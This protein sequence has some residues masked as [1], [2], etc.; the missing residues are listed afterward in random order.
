LIQTSNSREDDW[1]GAVNLQQW[2]NDRR[3][4]GQDDF[5]RE[6]DQF[7][8]ITGI[9]PGTPAVVDLKVASN[10]PAQFPKPLQNA[11]LRACDCGSSAGCALSTPIRRVRALCCARAAS[12][13]AAVAPP[14]SVM[15]SRRLMCCP[16]PEDRILHIVVD[17]PRLCITASAQCRSW[18]IRVDWAS[19]AS[20]LVDREDVEAVE[21][22]IYI[23]EDRRDIFR[24]PI[25]NK[26]R[27]TSSFLA[28]I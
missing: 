25:S 21:A 11:P 27:S 8:S 3:T 1:D 9:A 19:A 10:V 23:A 4:H 20:P 13:H 17:M 28:I 5:R 18:V 2:D 15:N 22:I 24:L 14:I 7:R 16:Q 26:V 12:G 6:R